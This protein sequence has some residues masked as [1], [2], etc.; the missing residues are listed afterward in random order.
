[1]STPNFQLPPRDPSMSDADYITM[2]E[3]IIQMDVE[4][5][6]QM[7]IDLNSQS[8]FLRAIIWTQPDRT[9]EIT[10]ESLV[11]TQEMTS[12]VQTWQDPNTMSLMIRLGDRKCNS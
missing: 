12:G 1:M 6:R 10:P 2:L 7:R 4:I 8:A 9:I 5:M 11:A 3:S